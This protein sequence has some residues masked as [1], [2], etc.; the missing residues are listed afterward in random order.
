MVP[1]PLASLAGLCGILDKEK[2]L[3]FSDLWVEG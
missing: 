1:L 3:N 2:E